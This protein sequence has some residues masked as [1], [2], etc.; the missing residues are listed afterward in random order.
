MKKQQQQQQQQQQRLVISNTS[1]NKH[2]QEKR[3]HSGNPTHSD[4]IIIYGYNPCF[5]Y[6]LVYVRVLL[7]FWSS[8]P[9]STNIVLES[10]NHFRYLPILQSCNL[11]NWNAVILGKERFIFFRGASCMFRLVG[12]VAGPRRGRGEG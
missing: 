10:S 12:I 6:E 3:I 1:Q 2:A 8:R 5:F 7:I 4:N 11:S 9:F